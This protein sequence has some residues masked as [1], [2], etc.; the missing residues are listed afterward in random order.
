MKGYSERK[1]I[2]LEQDVIKSAR[3]AKKH[4][5]KEDGNCQ[6]QLSSIICDKPEVR[7]HMIIATLKKT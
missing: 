1:H 2:I 3:R 4:R 6:S 5:R 7:K